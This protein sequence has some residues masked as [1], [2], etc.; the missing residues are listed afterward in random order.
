M[1]SP[2]KLRANRANARAST[3]PRTPAGKARTARNAWRHGLA[4]SILSNPQLTSEVEALA[5]DI[6]GPHAN[7]E[8]VE[9][10]LPVAEAQIDIA[11]VRRARY[12]LLAGFEG[13]E[14]LAMKLSDLVPRLAVLDRY[15]ARALSRRK[16]AIR[17]LDAARR[18]TV[19]RAS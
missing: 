5:R 8:I 16:L 4:I 10:S 3:G 11:R 12:D 18:R 1:I 13:R 7:P 17:A 19:P 9:L 15:E 14:K 6:A 2:R